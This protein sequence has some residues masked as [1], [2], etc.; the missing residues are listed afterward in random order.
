MSKFVGF[1][2]LVPVFGIA[3]L[4]EPVE[5]LTGI[6]PLYWPLKALISGISGESLVYVMIFLIIG[7]LTQGTVIGYL[8]RSINA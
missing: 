8:L 2:I 4:P 7:V 5:Y 3:L 6:V 1:S